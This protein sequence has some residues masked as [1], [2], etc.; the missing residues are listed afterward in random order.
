MVGPLPLHDV[1][2][3]RLGTDEM[4]RSHRSKE[5]RDAT[6]ALNTL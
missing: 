3:L 2:R 6:T 1:A 4:S 5:L